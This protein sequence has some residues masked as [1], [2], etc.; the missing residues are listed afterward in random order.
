MVAE[1]EWESVEGRSFEEFYAQEYHAVLAVARVLTGD[2]GRAEDVTHDAFAAAFEAWGTVQNP[3][4]W[5]RRVVANMSHS[6]WRRRYAEQRALGRVPPPVRVGMDVPSGP[7]RFGR[8]FGHSP[9]ARR[10]RLPCSIWMIFLYRTL[11]ASWDARNRRPESIS[12]AVVRR[13][14]SAWT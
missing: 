7:R 2:Q 1:W 9:N 10:R 13:W 14:R 11:L 5:I 4:G 12:P 3:S 6:A 8:K